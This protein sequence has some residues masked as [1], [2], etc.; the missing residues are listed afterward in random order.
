[1][2]SYTH[3]IA[4]ISL[5]AGSLLSAHAHEDALHHW[6]LPSKDPDRIVLTLPGDPCTTAGITWRTSTEINQ[7]FVDIAIATGA[8]RF[9]LTAERHTAT[10]EPVAFPKS[11]WNRDFT[12]HYHSARIEGLKPDT[13]YAYRVGDGDRFVSE[14]IQFRTASA[15]PKPI[16][17]LYFG[18]AQNSVLS[19]WSRV[20]RA[21]YQMAPNAD[22][23]LHAGDLINRAH[24]DSEWAE[25]FK[26]GGWIHAS[27]PTVPVA[28]N[29]EYSHM[30]TN[31]LMREKFLSMHW[32][33]Q[34]NLPVVQGLPEILNETVYSID[35]PN[36]R[37]IVLNSNREQEE[38][39][40]WL[41]SQLAGAADK[42]T[43]VS[44][45]HPVF[46]SGKDRDNE[47]L[48]KLWKPV[49]DKYKVDLLL[50]G[51]DHTYARGQSP[52]T[53]E[54][55][56]ETV[57]SSQQV[58]T[59][60]VNSVSGPKMYEFHKNGWDGYAEQDVSLLKKAENTQ[61][62]QVISIEGNQ[63]SYRA[64]TAASELYDAFTLTKDTEGNKT[65]QQDDAR[66]QTRLFETTEPY[67]RDD[68][69]Y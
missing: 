65:I 52:Q 21:A 14:W 36:L 23:A 22:F 63:L 39:I 56:V 17:F 28:G 41:E 43:V 64:Y 4:L 24:N 13:L 38:Q 32:Q 18:D 7:G 33:P 8:P 35:Y 54:H 12:V 15:E 61:F 20:I 50:Q 5:I 10:T 67:H 47:D 1:M 16:T 9:D 26:A 57:G 55:T 51:H 37:V 59:V 6:E 45:H 42:W 40:E 25:W 49:F 69:P 19:H 2:K 29:H 68:M 11:T 66:T 27:T 30:G 53:P 44:F 34:F 58:S 31:P 62:F 3:P 60:Y 48:R 46:S